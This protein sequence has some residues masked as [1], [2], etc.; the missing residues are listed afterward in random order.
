MN[1]K[2]IIKYTN[3]FFANILNFILPRNCI[4]CK[5]IIGKDYSGLNLCSNC[6]SKIKKIAPPYCNICGTPFHLKTEYHRICSDCQK[7][8]PKYYSLYAALEYNNEITMTLIHAF[9]YG[10]KYFLAQDLAFFMLEAARINYPGLNLKEIDFILP[11]PLHT[12]K[13]RERGFNQSELLAE[14]ISEYTNIPYKTDILFRKKDTISQSNL[15]K[16]IRKKNIKNAFALNKPQLIKNKKI[17][18]IDDVST[19]GATVNE[20]SKILLKEGSEKIQVLVFAKTIKT[21]I[22]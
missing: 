5:S 4:N 19:T 8:K 20:C 13:K 17:L 14:Y 1:N 21:D 2:N 10:K 7:N 22:K 12:R 18:L 6:Y 15:D 16:N 11:V 9:K 3:N